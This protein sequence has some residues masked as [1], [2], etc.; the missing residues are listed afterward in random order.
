MTV[1]VCVYVCSSYTIKLNAESM[2]GSSSGIQDTLDHA[3]NPTISY[4][5]YMITAAPSAFQ[6]FQLVYIIRVYL[7]YDQS[8]LGDGELI[9]KN[10]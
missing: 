9:G 1:C 4:L 5:V 6:K 10:K 8:D 2:R 3:V 7:W